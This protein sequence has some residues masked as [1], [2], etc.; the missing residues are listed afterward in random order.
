M[1]KVNKG[2][3]LEDTLLERLATYKEGKFLIEHNDVSYTCT[4]F[5]K[6]SQWDKLYDYLNLPLTIEVID[7]DEFN[8]LT[9]NLVERCV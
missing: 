9:V 3:I 4:L 2:D 5:D 1:C 8:N 7:V 6:D